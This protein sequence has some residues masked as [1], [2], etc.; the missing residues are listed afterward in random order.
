MSPHSVQRLRQE[1][2]L[3]HRFVA[4]YQQKFVSLIDQLNHEPARV[5]D[6]HCLRLCVETMNML[7]ST[8]DQ[9]AGALREIAGEEDSPRGR[10]DAEKI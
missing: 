10:G 3:I 7:M 5:S 4:T 9:I 2:D 8:Q 6:L 1:A